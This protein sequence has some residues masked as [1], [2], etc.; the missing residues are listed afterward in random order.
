MGDSVGKKQLLSLALCHTVPHTEVTYRAWG[1][2]KGELGN[3]RLRAP[4]AVAAAREDSAFLIQRSRP[5]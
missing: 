1:E 5:P 3:W 4:A 2:E